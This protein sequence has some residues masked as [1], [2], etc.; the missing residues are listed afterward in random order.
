MKES[1][2]TSK[3]EALQLAVVSKSGA[4]KIVDATK[5]AE[6]KL[7]AGDKL[8]VLK[9]AKKEAFEDLVVIQ[10]G[11]NLEIVY[12]DG[13][14]IALEGFYA[15]DNIALELPTGEQEMHLL[16]SNLQSGTELS[17]IY[18]QGD[19]SAF[20][21]MFESND[22]MLQALNNYNTS[23]DSGL[24]AAGEA[25]AAGAAEGAAAGG[26]A[27]AGTAGGMFAG[28][29]TAALVVGG[30]VVAGVAVAASNDSSSSS[31]TG[32][33]SSL[34]KAFLID[35]AV[36]GADYY[37][38]G[39]Y[40]GKTAA[41]G[42]FNYSAGDTITF[43]IG[44]I[45]LGTMSGN[46]IPADG[47]VMP[48]DIVGVDRNNT[49]D[50]VVV[51]MARILQT[52]VNEEGTIT[53]PDNVEEIITDT[54]DFETIL[55][56]YI[57]G[58]TNVSALTTSV[59]SI[60]P[61]DV[62]YAVPSAV[63]AITHLNN[64]VQEIILEA[65]GVSDIVDITA[66]TVEELAVLIT[67]GKT[68][69]MLDD[70]I[71]LTDLAAYVTG[72]SLT[73][74]QAD[75][76]NAYT[77]SLTLNNFNGSAAIALTMTLSQYNNMT[78]SSAGDDTVTVMISDSDANEGLHGE[79]N[80]TDVI[81]LTN[82]NLENA[83]VIMLDSGVTKTVEVN[84]ELVSKINKNGSSTYIEVEDTYTN[85]LD[86]NLTDE[87][88]TALIN[89]ADYVTIELTGDTDLSELVL[90]SSVDRIITE[91]YTLTTSVANSILGNI[92]SVISGV[93]GEF[94]NVVL[95]D[96]VTNLSNVS[97]DIVDENLIITD[98]ATIGD[99]ANLVSATSGAVS[100]S[101]IVDT[102]N[103]LTD[104][105]NADYFTSNP[106]I[107]VSL[108]VTVSE[109]AEINALT[110][111][112]LTYTL[113]DTLENLAGAADG[114][115]SGAT[116]YDITGLTALD[117]DG[118]VNVQ[119][120][121]TLE[122]ALLIDNANALYGTDT[123]SGTVTVEYTLG[124]ALADLVGLDS[125]PS[126]Y[127]LSDAVEDIIELTVEEA[128]IVLGATNIADYEFEVE[129][130]V[131]NLTGEVGDL[132]ADQITSV[133]V[134]IATD[135]SENDLT[136]V[137]FDADVTVINLEGQTDVQLTVSQAETF[138]IVTNGGTY[139]ITDTA[140]ALVA[141]EA[142]NVNLTVTDTVTLNQ[143][144][145]IFG[146]G[147]GSTT[148][149]EGITDTA[150]NLAAADEAIIEDQALTVDG[151]ATILELTTITSK[152]EV[153]AGG[154]L[155]YSVGGISDT[156]ENLAIDALTNSG[157]G[158]FVTGAVNV[159]LTDAH[160][161]AQLKAIND[162]TSGT[163]TLDDP[164]VEL[165]GTATDIIAAL[166]G[167]VGYTGTITVTTEDG[168]DLRALDLSNADSIV[169]AN[170]D[171]VDVTLAQALILDTNTSG[172][173]SIT[174]TGNFDIS[175]YLPAG[176]GVGKLPTGLFDI[177]LEGT[178]PQTITI[179]ADATDIS[180]E[181]IDDDNNDGGN[182][183]F[184]INGKE[185]DTVIIDASYYGTITTGEADFDEEADEG[186]YP[187]DYI[188]FTSSTG[189]SI[190]VSQ[191]VGNIIISGTLSEL[192]ALTTLP[193]AY[194]LNETPGDLGDLTVEE[195]TLVQGATNTVDYTYSIADTATAILTQIA[196]DTADTTTV[197]STATARTANDAT[198][199][200]LTVEEQSTLSTASVTI[201]AGYNIVDTAAA[202]QAIIAAGDTDG[203]L[204]D[205][206]G[207]TATTSDAN[208]TLT[209][210]QA[211]GLTIEGTGGVTIESSDGNQT[212]NIATEGTNSITAGQGSDTITLGDAT[213]IDTI[214]IGEGTGVTAV[215]ST[216][217][218][219]VTDLQA[220]ALT[221][222]SVVLAGVNGGAA[223]TVDVSGATD[224]AT[225]AAAVQAA[226]R[227]ADADATDISVAWAGD[228]L[229]VT[230]AL[231][232]DFSA[233]SLL[234]DQVTPAEVD[235]SITT[236]NGSVAVAPAEID[237]TITTTNGSV[238]GLNS[239]EIDA[240]ITTTNG[241]VAGVNIAEIDAAITTTNGSVAVAPA[242]IDAT[243]TTTNGN[244]AVAAES[245]SAPAS[246]DTIINFDTTDILDLPTTTVAADA[247]IGD[248]NVAED[249]TVNA[250]VIGSMDVLNG[251]ASF[252]AADDTTG[253][254]INSADALQ[255]AL[256]YLS[257][258]DVVANGDTVA[259]AWND[260]VND[261]TMVFQGNA[262]GDIAVNLQGV[263][264]IADL[265]T[266]V[267]IG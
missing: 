58:T 142:T 93:D 78:V 148:L 120:T 203:I 141:A 151:A 18:A 35:S 224:G 152:L 213:G 175:E 126:T 167:I 55:E 121:V 232:R 14:S 118:A 161:L 200:D 46:D 262:N 99:I 247:A 185:T 216:V 32:I 17:I 222:F 101:T 240:I 109:Y 177:V 106:D 92:A 208:T 173:Y 235:A 205:A 122:E 24:N 252:F 11:D 60:T 242:E 169:V 53:I 188:K 211:D 214:V 80:G 69:I 144:T 74:A 114:V 198:A 248:G 86:E 215:A 163:I 103:V 20:N 190:V 153:D 45:T 29:S 201:T 63:S 207:V 251:V 108:P 23:I 174:L 237:A 179:V 85:L 66:S 62:G 191:A 70:T 264:G 183:L 160:N 182:D 178:A 30:V 13:T 21:G 260:G 147:M 136:E 227:T 234:D 98:E 39:V 87:E 64:T 4:I 125:L 146:L 36:G 37:I 48:Q 168:D 110:T 238:A 119:I 54:I 156:A 245:D 194:I 139:G 199:V 149:L 265:S 255:A 6:L 129:D 112:D 150:A 244:I 7:K 165:E 171:Y 47:K 249:A 267:I 135:G 38:N 100:Y 127:T 130:S 157:S 187:N 243:I 218:I 166:D 33:G 189:S 239:A 140:T 206:Q 123:S 180:V 137:T 266:E 65:A 193:D 44:N 5:L 27:A 94:P 90:H 22:A 192:D 89:D 229:T 42:S 132:S 82:Y 219:D 41:D 128:L 195:A 158:T 204:T 83:D 196:A 131:A 75:A 31:G 233:A 96:T 2:V 15:L 95:K 212:L 105:A 56:T 77:G 164:S 230:D 220:A 250:V 34:K 49:T 12:A 68:T 236:T 133:M 104:S 134:S 71:D 186:D 217:E 116:N 184:I 73:Q 223:N 9:D 43:K 225:L 59:D 76:I 40:A 107:N 197:I 254:T 26:T 79:E 50:P 28:V 72:E 10:K 241:N 117:E 143:Y 202:I 57:P 155:D 52:F 170:G 259:F 3:A 162:A 257:Q 172:Q 226:L 154:S 19:M 124:V 181:D 256:E 145:M 51:A 209:A 113:A 210:L 97:G 111:G 16:S 253:V 1:I 263:T 25:A 258:D 81:N 88:K 246:F 61:T 228:V 159:T 84:V 8:R 138:D 115:V 261:N 231:G 102:Y 221:D 91:G 176:G 67:G